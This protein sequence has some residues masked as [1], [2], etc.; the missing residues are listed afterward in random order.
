MDRRQ[1]C[2]RGVSGLTAAG[3]GKLTNSARACQADQAKA[4][5]DPQSMAKAGRWLFMDQGK[6][7]SEALLQ[8]GCDAMGIS[9][10][11][12]PDA[13][14]GL[15]GGVGLHGRTCGAITGAAM[16]ISLA[17]AQKL[18]DHNTKSSVAIDATSKLYKAFKERFGATDCREL[19][20]LD[21]T[22]AQGLADLSAGVKAKKCAA[23]VEFAAR[24]LSKQLKAIQ[25]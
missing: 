7:C 13:A 16:A 25:A 6:S 10:E 21:L 2:K 12:V 11:L 23:F 24:E 9:S 18:A 17:A 14:M 19:I 15:A 8:V 1:F 5:D 3:L 4:S 20:D 22:T